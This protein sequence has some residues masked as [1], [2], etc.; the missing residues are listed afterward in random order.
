MAGRWPKVAR[1]SA[2][3]LTS[4][5]LGTTSSTDADASPASAATASAAEEPH[6]PSIPP[7]CLVVSAPR[8]GA[9]PGNAA[10]RA[11]SS[12]SVGTASTRAIRSY[13]RQRAI[14]PQQGIAAMRSIRHSR[15]RSSSGATPR[16]GRMRFRRTKHLK[17]HLRCEFDR[18]FS[19]PSALGTPPYGRCGGSGVGFMPGENSAFAGAAGTN[20]ARA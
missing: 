16:R 15:I 19:I 20:S 12:V 17:V 3:G 8:R 13:H 10:S 11:G 14:T 7:A 4:V 2:Q 5:R 9:Q 1:S 18:H 6:A